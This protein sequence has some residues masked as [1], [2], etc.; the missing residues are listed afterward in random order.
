MRIGEIFRY[1]RPYDPTMQ[2]IDG[3]PNYFHRAFTPGSK[4]P[5]LEAGVNPIASILDVEGSSRRPAILISSSP[6]K[7]GSLETPWVDTFDPDNGHIRYYGDNKD[8]QKDPSQSPGNKALLEAY[9]AHASPQRHVRE[10]FAVPILFFER[11]RHLGR[12]KG[13]VCFQGFGVIR[14][15]QLITQ[16]DPKHARYFSN[17]VFDFCVFSLTGEN[18]IF[19]W[20]W[21]GQR[22]N[23][24]LSASATLASAPSTWKDWV[25]YGSDEIERFRRRVS[26]TQLVPTSEQ[27]PKP[28]SSEES[29]LLSVYNF[30]EGR[31]HR[32][33]AL[34]LYITEHILQSNGV[35]FA[36]GWVTPPSSDGGAD[37]VGRMQVGT[38]LSSIKLILLG[39]AKCEKLTS[40]TNGRDVARVVARLK[41]GWIGVYVTTSFFS[42]MV[43][44][45]IIED[46]YPVILI[47]GLKIAEVLAQVMFQQGV[48]D[49]VSILADIDREYDSLIKRRRPEEVLFV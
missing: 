26:V 1:S 4:L 3:L 25:R 34:A 16:Y 41:R 33:E 10:N 19:P 37:F 22:R 49:I 9:K 36:R 13:N 40:P 43:Q 21:I 42:G 47:N 35:N 11:V 20:R 46:Q 15:I 12:T 48:N 32:F 18:E 8:A 38:G 30:Y 28:D 39:Q 17:Y 14:S 24:A 27:R 29:I 5:L 7:V 31:K 6:H 45:E 2:E 23:P 44:Q